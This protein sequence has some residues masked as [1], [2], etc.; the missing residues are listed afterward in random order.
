MRRTLMALVLAGLLLAGAGVAWAQEKVDLKENARVNDTFTRTKVSEMSMTIRDKAGS[1]EKVLNRTEETIGEKVLAVE[2]GR[3]TKIRRYYVS[4][5]ETA[6]NAGTQGPMTRDGE[7]TGRI[8][9][10]TGVGA[11]AK[12]ECLNDTVDA[13]WLKAKVKNVPQGIL[14]PGRPVAVGESWDVPADLCKQLF[15]EGGDNGVD[16]ASLKC[17]LLG[18]EDHQG[19]KSAK[20][21]VEMRFSGD[22]QPG[23]KIVMELTG[24]SWF[25]IET[26]MFLGWDMKGT[27]TLK[28]AQ[29]GGKT[30]DE[31]VSGTG[32]VTMKET[33][34][35]G[36]ADLGDE[37][38]KLEHK[39]TPGDGG[40]EGSKDEGK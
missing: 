5:K 8:F 30:G 26:G 2:N 16:Q 15:N 37:T 36:K 3:A 28:G 6:Q 22:A 40:E 12:A 38:K 35:L 29:G 11:T 31:E 39:A 1:E 18:I 4:Q 10:I 9:V 19:V 17:K 23:S 21:G 24:E 27:M 13:E 7:S 25:G 33:V 34:G 32:P 20:L 14:L